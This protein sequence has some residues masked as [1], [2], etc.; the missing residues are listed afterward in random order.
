M[1]NQIDKVERDIW[2]I[3]SH[4]DSTIMTCGARPNAFPQKTVGWCDMVGGKMGL[5][6]RAE[7]RPSLGRLLVDVRVGLGAEEA[8]NLNRR[9]KARTH[10]VR[11]GVPSLREEAVRNGTQTPGGIRDGKAAVGAGKP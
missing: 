2:V 1:T 3:S 9:E 5:L 8:L 7:A 6:V 11:S 4:S 10:G